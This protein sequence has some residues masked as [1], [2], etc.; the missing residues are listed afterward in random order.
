[1]T[2]THSKLA[3]TATLLTLLAITAYVAFVEISN[4][5]PKTMGYDEAWHIFVAVVSPRW[6]SALAMSAD[7]HP[8]LYYPLLRALSRLGYDPFW[9]RLL[10]VV[11]TILC[12]PLWYSLLRKLKVGVLTALVGTVVLASAYSF[13]HVGVLVRSYAITVFLLIGALWFWI[14]LLPGSSGQ[15]RRRSAVLSLALFSLAFGFLYAGAFATTAVFGATLLVMASSGDA[16]Q[17]I[18]DNWRQHS[19]WPEWAAFFGFHLLIVGWFYIGWGQNINDDIPHYLSAFSHNL[20]QSVAEFLLY[21]TRLEIAL[22]TPLAGYPDWLL[23][24]GGVVIASTVVL[25]TVIYLRTGNTVRAVLMLTPI[26]LTTIL[27]ALSIIEKFPFGGYLRHQY[28]LFPFLLLLLPLA[29]DTLWRRF[30]NAWLQRIGLTLVLAIAITNAVQMQRSNPIPEA[31]PTETW[32]KTY[33]TLFA[34]PHDEPIFINAHMFYPTF[35]NRYPHGVW[36]QFS[37][38]R[39]VQGHYYTAHQGWLSL[40]LPWTPYEQYGAIAAD[41]SHVVLIRDRHRFQ[42]FTKPSE[43][44]FDQVRGVLKAMNQTRATIL[45]P[46]EAPSKPIDDQAIRDHSRQF[47]FETIA[48]EP[49]EDSVL[50]TIEAIAN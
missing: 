30:P 13:L 17:A 46:H 18:V 14:D 35:M 33:E 50:L 42:F 9:P 22:F 19:R 24:L 26:L 41:G 34:K 2:T 11:P 16:R 43:L 44:F 8:P 15:P 27:A 5:L 21:T 37:Y 12:V 39:S 10:S 25:L 47:G 6:H 36:Y 23:D 38:Q 49:V 4:A 48:I 40:L 31:P 45:V 7:S 3:P 20:E 29:L 28:V 1:M 32:A